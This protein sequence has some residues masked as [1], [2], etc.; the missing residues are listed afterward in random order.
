[1]TLTQLLFSFSGRISR[2]PYWLF[3]L[4]TAVVFTP[5]FFLDL[6]PS[7]L[8][9]YTNLCA[10]VLLWPSLAIQAKRWHD[11]DKSAW[12][13]LINFVPLIGTIWSL[14]ENGF[15]EGTPNTNRFGA[16]PLPASSAN[17]P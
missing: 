11:R 12:W 8:D 17:G 6:D 15:L 16:N 14:V 7:A 3:V 9:H 13:I 5:F 2:K 1:M 4:A 10:L